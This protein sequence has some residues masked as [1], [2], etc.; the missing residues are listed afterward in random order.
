M[1]LNLGN[2]I[3][4]LRHRD[5]RTQEDLAN[6]LGVTSQAVSRW[7]SGGSYPDMS[8][9]PSIANFFG[10]TIDE[11]FGY[12]NQ[13]EQKI[14]ALVAQIEEMEQQN[15]GTD[16]NISEC[17][18]LAR[19]ALIEFPGN[20]KLMLCLATVLNTAGY[21]RHGEAHLIDD[22]GYGVYDVEKHKT[23]AEWS[24][25]LPLYEKALETLPNGALRNRAIDELSQLYLNLGKHDKGMALADS[26]PDLWGCREFL[27]AY[28]CDGKEYVKAHSQTLLKTVR[29]CAVFIVN[30]TTADQRHLSAKEKADCLSS[31]IGLFKLICPDE[32]YGYH[33]GYIASLKMLLSLYLWVDGRKDDAFDVLEQAADH[34]KKMIGLCE[35]GVAHYS[36]PL[37]RLVEENAPCSAEVARADL[38]SMPEDWP[39]WTVPEVAQAKAEIQKDPRWNAWVSKSIRP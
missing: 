17:I 3:R 24:E 26:A 12:E 34:S 2:K 5:G 8:L 29:A 37:V 6:V 10:I 16:V 11:L 14:N 38:L 32:N 39:W 25:A 4:A 33:H 13:R 23:Y 18:A 1:Q 36:A 9:I 30:I 19:K 22:E 7:E 20:E 15:R 27:R 21:V 28:A 31:A 35:K